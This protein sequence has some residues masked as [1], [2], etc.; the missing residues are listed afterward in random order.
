MIVEFSDEIMKTTNMS[1]KD[2]KKELA[3]ALYSNKT[4]T[5]MQASKLA[6]IDFLDF[7]SLMVERNVFI[8]YD[9]NDF[10]EDLKTLDIL[11]RK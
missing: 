10:E 1:K 6:G 9:E 4:L 3:L 5:L 11:F 8:H 7:Q 2:I